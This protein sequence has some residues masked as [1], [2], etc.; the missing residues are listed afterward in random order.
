MSEN[1]LQELKEQIKQEILKEMKEPKRKETVWSKIKQ[2]FEEEAKLFNYEYDETVEGEYGQKY[3]RKQEK[4]YER[5]VFTAIG[6][7]LRL[8]YKERL[9][10]NIEADYEEV[11][12]IVESILGIMK[13]SQ[14][15]AIQS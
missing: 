1:E 3:I 10:H 12:Q 13:D 15:K 8:K 5:D 2:E 9:V 11:K 4:H 6:T 7:L 14:K